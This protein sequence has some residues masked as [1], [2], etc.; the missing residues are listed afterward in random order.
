MV[1]KADKR[2]V[3]WKKGKYM[4]RASEA[5]KEATKNATEFFTKELS[6]IEEQITKAIKEGK[7]LISCSGYL[8]E[9]TIGVLKSLGYKVS[10][11]SQYNEPYYSI[12]WQ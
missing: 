8:N 3:S 7:Y 9:E 1:I 4:I 5:N 10:T 12:S 2:F 11:G 6:D